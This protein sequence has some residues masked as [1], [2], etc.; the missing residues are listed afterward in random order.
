MREANRLRTLQ[1]GIARNNGLLV[2]ARGIQQAANNPKHVGFQRFNVG[3]A[4]QT[5]IGRNLIVTA[6]AGVQ[7][8]PHIAKLF[9]QRGFDKAVNVFFATGIEVNLTRFRLGFQFAECRF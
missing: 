5:E 2:A 9:N 7:L 6:A 1:V 3:A 4:P 8:T